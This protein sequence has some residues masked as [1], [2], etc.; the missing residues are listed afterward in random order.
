MNIHEISCY[1][2]LNQYHQNEWHQYVINHAIS[3]GNKQ[4]GFLEKEALQ[5]GLNKISDF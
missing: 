2:D 3:I 1:G 4:L 5:S